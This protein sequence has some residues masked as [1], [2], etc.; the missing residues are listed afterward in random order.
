MSD[1][2]GEKVLNLGENAEVEKFFVARATDPVISPNYSIPGDFTA[3][4]PTPLDPTE[5]IAMCEEVTLLQ[6]IP[7]ERTALKQHTWRELN[8][9]A[10]NSG[11]SYL[12]FADGYC[13]EE[14]QHDGDNTTIT[15]KNI[16]AK[17]SLG[18]SDIMHSAAV[19]ASNWHGI[20]TLVGGFPSGE[21][22]PG[23]QDMATFQKERVMDLKEK[24]VRLG[25]TLVLNGE[26]RLL[27]L[28]NTNANSLEFDGIEKW[29]TNMSCTMHTRSAADLAASGSFSALSFDR[30]LAEGC[31]KPTHVFGHS[32]SVQEMM[33]AYF[34]LGFQ[35]SEVVNFNSGNRITPGYN[36]ASVVNTGIGPLTVVADNNFTRTAAGGFAFQADLWTLRMTHNGEK[37]VYRIT[38]IPFSILDLVPGCTAIAFEIWKKTALVI[39]MCCAQ[40]QWRGIFTGRIYSGCPTVY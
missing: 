27:A 38:Q 5:F 30:F 13:P 21:G 10:F 34:Q 17:K 1:L 35:G 32:T 39:K 31:A 2:T 33:S 11:S 20:N 19:A 6:A 26:D 7:E 3:Q 29:A 8:E 25:A 22:L 24:E 12:A 14:Y 37:L 28:G 40:G 4:Y 9:L 23:A 16:G 36:F 15:L 18:I